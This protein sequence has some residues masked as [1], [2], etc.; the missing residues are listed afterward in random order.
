M[1][2]NVAMH[3]A[4]DSVLKLGE[5]F[6]FTPS[7]RCKRNSGQAQKIKKYYESSLTKSD[8]RKKKHH[9]ARHLLVLRQLGMLSEGTLSSN[10]TYS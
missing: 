6:I 3:A 10:I 1:L 5:V 4:P 9:Q 7:G 8:F 2:D